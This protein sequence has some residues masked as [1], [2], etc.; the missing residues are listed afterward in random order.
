[1]KKVDTNVCFAGP[2]NKKLVVETDTDSVYRFD[3]SMSQMVIHIRT[4]PLKDLLSIMEISDTAIEREL[5]ERKSYLCDKALSYLKSTWYYRETG[6]KLIID[7][8]FLEDFLNQTVTK[9]TVYRR[10]KDRRMKICEVKKIIGFFDENSFN[11]K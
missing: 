5:E 2:G 10:L 7:K 8:E 6:E 9:R 1:M 3:K 4:I 11:R